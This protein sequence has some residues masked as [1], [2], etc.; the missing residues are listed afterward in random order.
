MP[1][2]SFDPNQPITVA[3][4]WPYLLGMVGTL[5]VGVR[6]MVLRLVQLEFKTPLTDIKSELKVLAGKIEESHNSSVELKIVVA[7]LDE[8]IESIQNRRE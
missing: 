4:A 8:R 1:Q 3:T 7:R 5:F 6:R 2:S